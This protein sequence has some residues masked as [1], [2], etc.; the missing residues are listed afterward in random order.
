MKSL[1]LKVAIGYIVILGLL[2]GSIHYITLQYKILSS[3]Y[4]VEG[5]LS[6]RRE[7]TDHLLAL[8]LQSEA[9]SQQ[10]ALG[11]KNSYDKYQCVV[12]T[13]SSTIQRLDSL[14]DDT[15][16]H[17]LLDSLG[18]ILKEKVHIIKSL[19]DV[20][21]NRNISGAYL[22]QMEE[23]VAKYNS[24]DNHTQTITTVIKSEKSTTITRPQK[25]VFKRIANVFKPGDGDTITTTSELSSNNDTVTTITQSPTN[26]KNEYNRINTQAML[27]ES[28]RL[29]SLRGK[30][31]LLQMASNQL[32]AN[33][34]SL[35][36]ELKNV[37]TATRQ[38]IIDHENDVRSKSIATTTAIAIVAVL[39]AVLFFIVV[40]RDI[41]R[42][43][44]YRRELE[45]ARQRAEALLDA[46]EKL[47]L[48]I[49]HDI[50][51]P[52]GAIKGY[53]Q[54]IEDTSSV[55]KIEEY[56]RSI[57]SS[58]SHLLD[59]VSALQDYHK[60]DADT[61]EVSNESLNAKDLLDD[62]ARS[63]TPLAAGKG[64]EL[65]NDI[66]EST[67]RY[68]MG[69]TFRLRQIVENLMS[70]AVKYTC[71]GSVTLSANIIDDTLNISVADTGSGI[72]EAEQSVI[73]DEFSRLSNARGIE[74]S[75]LGLSI[76]AKSV[77]LLGGEMTLASAV[78]EGTTFCVALPVELAETPE[79]EE[80]PLLHDEIST[81]L[82]PRNIIIVDDDP[83]QL[84]FSRSMLGGVV[85]DWPVKCYSDAETAFEEMRHTSFDILFTD[86]QMPS[87]D[88]WEVLR[89]SK[90]IQPHLIVVAMTATANLNVDE[91]VSKGFDNVLP[92]PYTR[93]D[94]AAI[95]ATIPQADHRLVDISPL[96]QYA[97][98]DPETEMLLIAT[99]ADETSKNLE[100]ITAAVE[101]CDKK[102]IGEIAHK[103]LPTMAMIK[104]P[105]LASFEYFNNH[106]DSQQWAADD[107]VHAKAVCDATTLVVATLRQWLNDKKV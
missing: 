94:L 87:I 106:R 66:D 86:I 98:G 4:D 90:E 40:W 37:E 59:L 6:H 103:M 71:E 49:T 84:Q 21:A 46:R 64:L 79:C 5:Q 34:N 31:H 38:S 101:A 53:A 18:I 99:A 19:C 30:L 88:G 29:T 74:G 13:I 89:K 27:R 22:K 96:T 57:N 72:S 65:K 91:Y 15:V 80:S 33:T 12:D 78:G 60:L 24:M 70:N 102:R 104:V 10:A 81:N 67:H 56:T 95:L 28:Q 16:Q 107:E 23:L 41:T 75:G 45:E 93:Q 54:L 58:A 62:I 51:A 9:L 63:F 105:Q 39:L 11:D 8:T 3:S 73:F 100:S 97:D 35:L 77:S 92:K 26:I 76:V 14:T 83:I 43:N 2:I 7:A 85:P 68:I 61:I 17:R 50:K 47:M 42:S 55:E 48:T 36:N 1:S 69:D 20:A 52:A 25:N 44:R 82:S 32:T